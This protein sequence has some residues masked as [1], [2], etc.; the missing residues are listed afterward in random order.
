R[1]RERTGEF[2]RQ[3]RTGGHKNSEDEWTDDSAAHD[4]SSSKGGR[5][6]SSSLEPVLLLQQRPQVRYQLMG[7]LEAKS[8]KR[9]I[10]EA[11]LRLQGAMRGADAVVD[12][13]EEYLPSFSC[14]EVCLKGT[15]IRAVDQAGRN[16][17]R[18]RWYTSQVTRVGTR[19]LA[20]GIANL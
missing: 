16:E 14:T 10:A 3:L 11:D 7:T 2:A 1:S 5:P 12:L 8:H 15:A 17:L 9:W 18:A 19:M 20:A 13:Q 4:D 6:R